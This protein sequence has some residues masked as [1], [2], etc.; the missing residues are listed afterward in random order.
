MPALLA[1]LVADLL[2]VVVLWREHKVEL[3]D[4][5]ETPYYIVL[6]VPRIAYHIPGTPEY[7]KDYCTVVHTA[8]NISQS[9]CN[10]AEYLQYSRVVRYTETSSSLRSSAVTPRVNFRL[11]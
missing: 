7:T 11:G 10:T 6:H 8:T 3:Y 2:Y 9:L 5:L 1:N 4:S